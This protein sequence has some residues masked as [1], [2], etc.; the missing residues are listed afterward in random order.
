MSDRIRIEGIEF[1][2]FHGVSPEE[3]QVGHRYWVDLSVWGDFRK[4]GITDE[5]AD[6]VSYS[7]LARLIVETAT[8]QKFALLERL[9]EIIA[10]ATLRHDERIE[11]VEVTVG[12]IHPP[13]KV[14]VAR[15]SV[16]LHRTRKA[17][18]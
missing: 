3:Q 17:L 14:I 10:V 7:T 16:V 13:A 1:Y 4:A 2:A 8:T 12:K 18:P 6:T 5:L 15:A 9:G 11:E